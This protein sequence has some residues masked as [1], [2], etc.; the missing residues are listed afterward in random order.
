MSG[1]V[2]LCTTQSTA[3]VFDSPSLQAAESLLL[4]STAGVNDRV[5]RQMLNPKL[6][7]VSHMSVRGIR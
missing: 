6:G 2:S 4:L 3:K 7:E 1:S 5:C